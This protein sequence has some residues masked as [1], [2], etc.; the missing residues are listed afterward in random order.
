MKASA[1]PLN[2]LK[3]ASPCPAN[4]D[5]MYGD[6][7]KRFCG[8]CKL[9]VYNLSG[10]TKPEAEQLLSNSEGRLCVRYYQRA[11]GTVITQDCPVGWRQLKKR[12]SNLAAALCSLLLGVV[13][14]FAFSAK[15]NNDEVIVG[16]LEPRW[17]K[18]TPTPTPF[19]M[20]NVAVKPAP[21][22]TP[23][24]S[25]RTMG[26]I[27]RPTPKE[28]PKPKPSPSPKQTEKKGEVFVGMKEAPTSS[29]N[30]V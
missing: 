8:E 20:G 12:V 13:A 9:N 10:M 5:A 11:D 4:W 6:D 22:S 24:D 2:N 7:R 30:K 26:M 3:I 19:I 1:S 15:T 14:F 29:K 21:D 17:T 16:K 18:P 23:P 28:T 27:A 25:Y